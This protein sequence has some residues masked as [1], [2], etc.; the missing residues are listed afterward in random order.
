MPAV[1]KL[2]I[3][4]VQENYTGKEPT[5]DKDFDET[6][7]QKDVITAFNWYNYHFDYKISHAMVSEYL[8]HT[9][10]AHVATLW[11][12][13]PYRSISNGIGWLARMMTI[14]YPASIGEVKKVNEAISHALTLAIEPKTTDVED[15][16]ATAKKKANIQEIMREK[17]NLLGGELEYMLDT[18]IAD[19]IPTKYKITPISTI[20]LANI[21][22]QHVPDLVQHWENTRKEFQ[23]AYVGNDNDLNES[24]SD[25]TKI[26]LRN[27]VKFTDLIIADL[28]SYVAYKKVTKAPRKRKTITPA[29]QVHKL[30]YSKE[31]KD[32]KLT[33]V[34]AEKIIG[35][36]EMY[37]Y[38]PKKRK[39]HR[40]VADEA[41]GN[42]LMVKNNTI[43]GFD[44]NKTVMK[45]VRKPE[46]QVKDLM[47]A[48]RP[49]TRKYF[50]DIKAVEA[51][52][53]G[54]FA[55]DMIILK[56]F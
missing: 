27:L 4:K 56:V 52:L 42:A 30:K 23:D 7:R 41:A 21:L 15:E 39:I 32:L 1:S 24:Y 10:K 3:S 38:S 55:P 16:A 25:Y 43:I 51:K 45:T 46:V 17:A 11:K 37:V 9:D 19:G 8:I 5:W 49:K 34:K 48:S 12:K 33:S 54:R 6:T 53:S 35:S 50:N 29:M 22:P 44:P 18:Y 47:K 31:F 36:K 28:N 14:G 40:Y 2:K 20:K 26:K 13:V